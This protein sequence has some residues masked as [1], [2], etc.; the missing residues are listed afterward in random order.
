MMTTEKAHIRGTDLLVLITQGSRL[1]M[2]WCINAEEPS[3]TL[4]GRDF[5]HMLMHTHGGCKTT[6]MLD[7]KPLMCTYVT[8]LQMEE[9]HSV[10]NNKPSTYR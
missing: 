4:F 7:D 9:E 10:T 3:A 5:K 8:T 1:L 2:A 6:S